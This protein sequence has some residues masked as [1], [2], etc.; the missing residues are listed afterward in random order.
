MPAPHAFLPLPNPHPGQIPRAH[1]NTQEL[2]EELIEGTLF[3]LIAEAALGGFDLTRP[4]RQILT[5]LE[6]RPSQMPDEEA[7]GDAQQP[8]PISTDVRR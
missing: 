5:N 1:N 7:E 8:P 4:P 6:T 3:N 2:A